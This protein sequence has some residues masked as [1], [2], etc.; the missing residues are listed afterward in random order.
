MF[1]SSPPPPQ[2]FSNI[3]V[4]SEAVSVLNGAHIGLNS[5]L[6]RLFKQQKLYEKENSI[7]HKVTSNL[8]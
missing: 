6:G 5:S 2:L 8:K 7:S 4:L 3:S 1:L